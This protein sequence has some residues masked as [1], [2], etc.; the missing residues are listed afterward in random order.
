MDSEFVIESDLRPKGWGTITV[1]HRDGRQESIPLVESV[2]FKN[3]VVNSGRAALVRGLANQFGGVFDNWVY[4]MAFGSGGTVGG[5]PR[6]VDAG[7]T[8]L[9]GPVVA[10]KSVIST[11]N[12]SVPTQVTFTSVLLF[13]DSVGS[14]INEMGLVLKNGDYYSITTFGDIV[15]GSNLQLIVNWVQ[16]LL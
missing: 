5:V 1:C 11:I 10:V 15:K 3:A 14:T 9:W 8:G 2:P 6:Y 16:N 4:Q 12:P 13:D 7:R